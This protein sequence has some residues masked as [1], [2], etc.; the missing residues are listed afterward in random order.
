[1]EGSGRRAAEIEWDRDRVD[2]G[3]LGDPEFVESA[4]RKAES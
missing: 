1:M 4:R 2:S 3:A